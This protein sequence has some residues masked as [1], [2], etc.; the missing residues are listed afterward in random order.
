VYEVAG[1][2]EL[3][4]VIPRVNSPTGGGSGLSQQRERVADVYAFLFQQLGVEYKEKH[5]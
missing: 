1:G 3:S 4:E 2:K 5:P